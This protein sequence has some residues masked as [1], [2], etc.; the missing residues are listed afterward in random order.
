MI[1]RYTAEVFENLSKGRFISSNSLDR[2]QRQWYDDVEENFQDYYDFY[3]QIGYTLENGNGYCYFTR[4]MAK[5][6]VENKISSLLKWIDY[7]AFLKTYNALFGSGFTFTQSDI[8][9]QFSCNM[10]LKNMISKLFPGKNSNAE[11]VDALIGELLR[12]GFVEVENEID[13]R[14]KVLNSFSYIE[15]LV[16][17]IEISEDDEKPE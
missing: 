5:V 2:A 4:A 3:A 7:I 11:K 1:M 16:Q 12:E 8:V 9:I 13:E 6:D 17:C 15:D 14:Y 10:E